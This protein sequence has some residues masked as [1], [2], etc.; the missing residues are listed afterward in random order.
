MRV[1]GNDIEAETD[2]RRKNPYC[3]K[4]GL[5]VDTEL[6][7]TYLIIYNRLLLFQLNW[8]RGQFFL[9]SFSSEIYA[10]LNSPGIERWFSHLR[11]CRLGAA[12][13]VLS[14]ENTLM[15]IT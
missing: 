6:L 11:F 8:P 5:Q 12:H 3:T 15:I 10:P 9:Q 2:A 13:F 7:N 14:I 4:N 1:K